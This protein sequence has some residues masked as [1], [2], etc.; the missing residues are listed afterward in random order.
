[1]TG[2]RW[3]ASAGE[4]A[5]AIR[6]ELASGDEDHAMRLLLDGVNELPDAATAG[7]LDEALAEPGSTGDPRWDTLLAAA[8]RYRLHGIG[9]DPPAWTHKDPLP[10]FWWP[11]DAGP[12]RAGYDYASAPVELA[13][14]GIFLSEDDF[15]RA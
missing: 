5:A 11:L 7:L 2:R 6:H 9:I 8:I 14:V 15:T 10:R 12:Q 4:L 1:M 13:R 3:W